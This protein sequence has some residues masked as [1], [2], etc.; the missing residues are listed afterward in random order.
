MS[1][2]PTTFIQDFK[3]SE[4]N[5]VVV[6]YHKNC[7]DG[8]T[9]AAILLCG[10]DF[11]KLPCEFIAKQ[12]GEELDL[13]IFQ[14]NDFVVVVDFSFKR[15]VCEELNLKVK[16]LVILDHH[17]SAK[18]ELAGLPYAKFDMTKSGA[19]LTWEY[20]N[21]P[22]TWET[23]VKYIQDYDLWKHELPK[24]K[25]VHAYLGAYMK[26]NDLWPAVA[27]AQ[28]FSLGV[29]TSAYMIG[30]ALLDR[31]NRTIQDHIKSA[32]P[33]HIKDANGKEYVGWCVECTE[34]SI[35]STLGN[36][37]CKLAHSDGFIPEFAVIYSAFGRV[38]SFRSLNGQALKLA[39]LFGGGG[40]PNAAGA[41]LGKREA[42]QFYRLTQDGFTLV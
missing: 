36:E 4:A 34:K 30:V 9:A 14:P 37:L 27:L 28:D 8:T 12:Y 35:V 32:K 13:S 31:D 24:T 17:E 22:T 6:V 18:D 1:S 3:A 15:E 19:M 11:Y 39:K 20:A 23:F 40:H 33:C 16:R 42:M 2:E 7:K 25:E 21:K 26:L 29:P 38:L 10:I 41:N 5:R